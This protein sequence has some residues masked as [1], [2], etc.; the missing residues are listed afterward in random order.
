MQREAHSLPVDD[1]SRLQTCQF[2]LLLPQGQVVK[3]GGLVEELQVLLQIPPHRVVLQILP[4]DL[5]LERVEHRLLLHQLVLVISSLQLIYLLRLHKF[6]LLLLNY[7]VSEA[8]LH[9]ETVEGHLVLFLIVV[10]DRGS[11]TVVPLEP[12]IHAFLE[13]LTT[14]GKGLI[15]LFPSGI[16]DRGLLNDRLQAAGVVFFTL[17]VVRVKSLLQLL[18]HA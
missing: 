1:V 2:P 15:G 13:V 18:R 6:K 11:R 8:V 17:A 10:V 7:D 12:Q 14:L 4:C 16:D 3:R 9:L 5:L